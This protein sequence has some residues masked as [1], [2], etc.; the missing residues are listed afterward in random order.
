MT[1]GAR[2]F[3]LTPNGRGT[4]TASKRW[5]TMRL[6]GRARYPVDELARRE[7][8]RG[9]SEDRAETGQPKSRKG[10][11]KPYSPVFLY[12]WDSCLAELRKKKSF[13]YRNPLTGGPVMATM[14]ARL[15]RV[16]GSTKAIRHTG[17]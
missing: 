12:K 10:W 9:V 14:G 7:L 8:L 16:K 17:A 3:V 15:E 4:T 1:L 5:H 2:D 13:E 11:K 6:A